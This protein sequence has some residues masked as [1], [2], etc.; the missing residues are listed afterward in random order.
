M[1]YPVDRLQLL[2][3]EFGGYQ[4]I[5]SAPEECSPIAGS[6]VRCD[7]VFSCPLPSQ[8]VSL[9][10]NIDIDDAS[11]QHG[12]FAV[13]EVGRMTGK[14][15]AIGEAARARPQQQHQRQL[16]RWLDRFTKTAD[17][18]FST[19]FSLFRFCRRTDIVRLT[20]RLPNRFACLFD[21]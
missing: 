21:D 16:P 9:Y 7:R 13:N 4:S 8:D 15:F 20:C 17:S 6:V 10:Q 18:N 14:R 19:Y 3:F 2:V 11:P 12:M 1:N 5:F